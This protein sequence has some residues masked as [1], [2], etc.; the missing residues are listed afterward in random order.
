MAGIDK[1]VM[2]K[3]EGKK[4]WQWIYDND[5]KCEELTT[6]SLLGSFSVHSDG[7]ICNNSESVDWFLW[8]N[9]SLK[10]IQKRLKEQY[11]NEPPKNQYEK[12]CQELLLKCDNDIQKIREFLD[13]IFKFESYEL[14]W[15]FI[16]M[17]EKEKK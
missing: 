6:Y 17:L 9:C 11:S 13:R 14:E 4:Y 10:F 1:I 15:Y 8:H 12:I 3:K 16:D 2:N 5:E 7:A